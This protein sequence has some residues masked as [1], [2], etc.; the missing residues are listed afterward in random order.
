MEKG[1][2]VFLTLIL[3]AFNGFSQGFEWLPSQ[4]G[5]NQILIYEGFSLSYNEQHEQADWVAYEVTREE[6]EAEGDRCNCFARDEDVLTGSATE[7]DY[8]STGFDKGHL[9]PSASMYMTPNM[10]RESF[11]MSNMSPQLAALNREI[12]ADLEGWV[13]E[14]ADEYGRVYVVTG[15]V[16]V[17]PL[18]SIGRN[19]VTVPAYFYKAVLRFDGPNNTVPKTIGFLIPNIA[20]TGDLEDYVVPVNAIETLTGLDFFPSLSSRVENRAESQYELRQWGF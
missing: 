17:N 18:G 13:R 15:P 3:A 11:L 6:V 5:S 4:V 10:N 12:W 7:S 8:T 2:C 9:A 20:P 16:F 14:K 19:N 1:Y